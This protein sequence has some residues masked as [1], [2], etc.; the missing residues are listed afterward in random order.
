[1]N[2]L[3]NNYQSLNNNEIYNTEFYVAI[4]VRLSKEDDK[5]EK[6]SK[7]D[8]SESIENQIKFLTSFVK[9]QG[10]N[11]VDIYKD[12]GYTGTNFNRPDFIRMKNDIEL[13]KVNLVITKDL[14]RLGREYIET[15]FYIEKYFPKKNV[16]YIAVNDGIDTFDPDNSNNDITPF[17]AVMNDMYAKDIS[18]KVKSTIIIKAI[19]GECIKSFLPYGYKKDDKD[20]NKVVID[21]AVSDN[22]IKIFELYKS[23]KTKKEICDYLN[24][25]NID[26]PLRY[27]E[28]TTNYANPNKRTYLWSTSSV[29]KILRDRIYIGDLVQ[30][31]YSTISY[32]VKKTIKLDESKHIIK[33]NNHEPIIDKETFYYV[34][35]LLNK[36]ANEWNYSNRP[37]HLLKG[38][39][40]CSRCGSRV[41]YNKNHGKYFRII[42]SSY[43]KQGKEFCSNINMR[44]DYLIKNVIDS[45]KKNIKDYLNEDE[46][47]IKNNKNK[48][49]N[50]NKKIYQKKI[51]EIDN[52]IKNIYQD[53]VNGL[54][55]D[56]IFKNLLS[57]YQ[58]EKKMLETKLKEAQNQNKIIELNNNDT[59]LNKDIKKYALDFLNFEDY[60]KIDRNILIKLIDKIEVNKDKKIKIFYKFK[61]S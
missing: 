15:G 52:Y 14:S 12:D 53:K 61:K 45:L 1:M 29:T 59:T 54:I 48:R 33:E 57:N 28:Q 44:E 55:D 40:F 39:V 37:P 7:L 41:T 42:C 47:V 23:G 21:S 16:R 36:Q 26:T 32:K 27:K 50:N 34:Q 51:N 17:K 46:I 19:E 31:K 25:N 2:S 6:S 4:Y 58:K 3:Y 20:K 60:T 9:G 35:E 38:L 11:I 49:E 24:E 43:K 8:D 30:H 10:W 18:K 13:G 5:F 56:E 22:I